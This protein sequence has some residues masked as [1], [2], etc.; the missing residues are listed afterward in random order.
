MTRRKITN[1]LAIPP[2][3]LS[4]PG[5]SFQEEAGGETVVGVVL[6]PRTS[7]RVPSSTNDNQFLLNPPVQLSISQGDIS[8]CQG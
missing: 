4:S 8:Q 1:S 6:V 2:L 7:Q 3:K 5:V